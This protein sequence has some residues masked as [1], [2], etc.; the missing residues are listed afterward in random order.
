[1]FCSRFL[2]KSKSGLLSYSLHPPISIGEQYSSL[3]YRPGRKTRL[4]RK[5]IQKRHVNNLLF[6][7]QQLEQQ[8]KQQPPPQFR[9]AINRKLFTGTTSE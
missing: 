4:K 5:I 8:R 2:G 3:V 6:Q 9:H 1:M 7:K